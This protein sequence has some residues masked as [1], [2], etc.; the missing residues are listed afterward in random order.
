MSATA[1]AAAS[2]N[3]RPV[4]LRG[5][6]GYALVLLGGLVVS[7]VPESSPVGDLP[8]VGELR[9]STVGRMAG[10]TVVVLGLGLGG[11]AWLELLRRVGRGRADLHLTRQAAALWSL[12]LVLAPPMFSRDGWSYAAQGEMARLGISPYEAGP[13]VLA[14]PIVEAVDPRWMDTLTP[15][16]PLPLA[17]GALAGHVVSDP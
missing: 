8:L 5:L 16:G 2:A 3:V 4:L 17:W 7:V 14:G 9:S 13:S 12:P 10:L 1:A 6:V 15:Y 11:A